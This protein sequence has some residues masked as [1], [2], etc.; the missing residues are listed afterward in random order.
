MPKILPFILSIAISIIAALILN[1][2][3]YF[4]N[5]F[6]IS[7]NKY[8]SP[9]VPQRKKLRPTDYFA[10]AISFLSVISLSS[11]FF[12]YSLILGKKPDLFLLPIAIIPLIFFAEHYLYFRINERPRRLSRYAFLLPLLILSSAFLIASEKSSSSSLCVFSVF[13]ISSGIIFCVLYL[14]SIFPL[15][16][17]DKTPRFRAFNITEKIHLLWRASSLLLLTVMFFGSPVFSLSIK[18]LVSIF[19]LFLLTVIFGVLTSVISYT[20]PSLDTKTVNKA[21]I[22]LSVISSI[23]LVIYIVM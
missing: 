15:L 2:T 7:A 16:S 10:L 20:Q 4:R 12:K 17:D 23:F 9:I 21:A 14:A 3:N 18:S 19:I 1:S 13:N 11:L 22:F 5:L 6:R 8:F